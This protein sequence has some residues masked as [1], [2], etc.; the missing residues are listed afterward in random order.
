MRNIQ[1]GLFG[2]CSSLLVA[3]SWIR[4]SE[5]LVC[6]GHKSGSAYRVRCHRLH[7]MA[8]SSR[9]VDS[10]QDAS[11]CS[12]ACCLTQH[13]DMQPGYNIRVL[14]VIAM[15]AFGGLLC[16]VMLKYAGLACVTTAVGTGSEQSSCVRDLLLKR[17]AD[18]MA[19]SDSVHS[20]I[21]SSN[22]KLIS[23]CYVSGQFAKWNRQQAMQRR[24]T[25]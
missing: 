3:A 12:P 4:L 19:R 24:R 15:N 5:S 13:G 23:L 21:L 18:L 2:A 7:R 8:R 16:A 20:I 9:T 25:Y 1:L 11:V 14:L 17:Q 22:K 6:G 10:I